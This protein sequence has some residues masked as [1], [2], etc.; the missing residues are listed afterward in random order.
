[1]KDYYYLGMVAFTCFYAYF[2]DS[3]SFDFP[4]SF[5]FLLATSLLSIFIFLYVLIHN[6]FFPPLPP[7]E[8]LGVT[9]KK[10]GHHWHK[11]RHYHKHTHITIILCLLISSLFHYSADSLQKRHL[12]FQTYSQLPH[13][14]L[15]LRIIKDRG[16]DG[17]FFIFL[18][19]Q[20]LPEFDKYEGIRE[21]KFI[22]KMGS[23]PSSLILG[24]N[25]IL[26]PKNIRWTKDYLPYI[27][28]KVGKVEKTGDR[29][30][31]HS[32]YYPK[33]NGQQ[34]IKVPSSSHQSPIQKT[35]ASPYGKYL[36]RNNMVATIYTNPSQIEVLPRHP[37]LSAESNVQWTWSNISSV[38][39]TTKLTFKDSI[40][41]KATHYLAPFSASLFLALMSGEK[42]YLDY[43][44]RK[45]FIASGTYHLFALSG[46]HM[47]LWFAFFFVLLK[48][49]LLPKKWILLIVCFVFLPWILLLSGSPPSILRAYLIVGISG[50]LLIEDRTFDF[51][52][53][54]SFVFFMSLILGKQGIYTIYEIGFQFSFLS[55]LAI[56]LL[57]PLIH[58]KWIIPSWTLR[59][60]LL[61]IGIQLVVAPLQLYAFGYINFLSS[62]YNL[63]FGLIFP[64]FLLYCILF[65][66][67]PFHWINQYF[68]IALD[69]LGNYI[70][71]LSTPTSIDTP[72]TQLYLFDAPYGSGLSLILICMHLAILYFSYKLISKKIFDTSA[73][74]S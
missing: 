22:L 1:M 34:T 16:Y 5:A 68:A 30:P 21:M 29:V 25:F 19:Q 28:G 66:I 64:P 61:M 3:L 27:E 54:L 24:S 4:H 63:L 40:E 70:K 67:S 23:K 52:K 47:G 73:K 55:V 35:Q 6:K 33:V 44:A 59:A 50:Y 57:I 46:L 38:I 65:F 11:I 58:N 2:V 32:L 14:E 20:N 39:L 13:K 7:N 8:K 56:L 31:D 72:K 48:L 26:T 53:L 18:A 9:T 17:R 51:I 10:W 42:N 37:S 71:I 12:L 15:S 45:F 69:A 36:L 49:F 60:F 74:L 62:L 41:K 43:K